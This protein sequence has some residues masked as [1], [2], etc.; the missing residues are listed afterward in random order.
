MMTPTIQKNERYDYVYTRENWSWNSSPAKLPPG[1]ASL[2]D[3][4]FDAPWRCSG[5][6]D[7]GQ[8]RQRRHQWYRFPRSL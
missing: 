3:P 7:G 6:D 1:K 8:P 2:C 4:A 5:D